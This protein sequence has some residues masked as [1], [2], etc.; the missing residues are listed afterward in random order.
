M[1]MTDTTAERIAELE[2]VQLWLKPDERA[3]LARLLADAYTRGWIAGRD[4]AAEYHETKAR[5]Y[6]DPSWQFG[7]PHIAMADFHAEQAIALRAL[8]ATAPE[9][10]GK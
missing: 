2:K 8:A 1:P 4:A 3:A 9:G 5:M 10:D 7:E 6:R